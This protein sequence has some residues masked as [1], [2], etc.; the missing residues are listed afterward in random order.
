MLHTL[1]R[2]HHNGGAIGEFTVVQLMAAV[3]QIGVLN[4]IS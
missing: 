4:A 1:K 3:T 2:H